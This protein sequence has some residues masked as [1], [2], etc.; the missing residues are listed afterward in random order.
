MQFTKLILGALLLILIGAISAG[1]LFFKHGSELL[2]ALN[3]IKIEYLIIAM[4]CVFAFH[5]LDGLRIFILS[6]ALK[7]K[8]SVLYSVMLSFMGA[9]GASITPSQVGGEFIAVWALKKRGNTLHKALGVISIKSI[10]GLF[11]MSLFLPFAILQI[12]KEPTRALI[13][14][15]IV[16]VILLFALLSTKALKDTSGKLKRFRQS[17]KAYFLI[18]RLYFAKKKGFLALAFFLSVLAYLFYFLAG[19]ILLLGFNA[20]AGLIQSIRAQALIFLTLL[21]SPTPGG[22]GT[23]ELGGI[24]IFGE[25]LSGGALGAFIITWRVLTLYVSALIGSILVFYYLIKR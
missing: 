7:M 19:T 8:V 1:A 4:L 2:R 3:S 14:L 10:V 22:A 9:F 21:I 18:L 5:L 16:L 11:A 20:N 13:P 24:Y 15:G 17:T 12:L 23:A 25:F 6:R